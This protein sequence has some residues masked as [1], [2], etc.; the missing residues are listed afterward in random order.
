MPTSVSN[1]NPARVALLDDRPRCGPDVV[2]LLGQRAALDTLVLAARSIPGPACIAL[3]GPWGAGKSTLARAAY[4]E[5]KNHPGA[6]VVW[7][8]PWPYERGED[9]VTPLLISMKQQL[10][11][12]DT[13][14]N[15]KRL[16]SN[17]AKVALSFGTRALMGYWFGGAAGGMPENKG[18]VGAQAEDLEAVWE[19]LEIFHDAVAKSRVLF[20]QVVAE[21]LKGEI[22]EPRLYIFL[23]DLDR[24]L[25]DSVIALIEAVKL[26]LCGTADAFAVPDD[27]TPRPEVVFVFALDRTVVGEAI[28]TRYPRA[29]RYTGETYLEKIFDLSL[30]V[31]AASPAGGQDVRAM[32]DEIMS[33]RGTGAEAE[34]LRLD[35]GLA[36]KGEKSGG[37]GA[38]AQILMSPVFAN[39]RVMKRTWNRLTLL[40]RSPDA[41]ANV[42]TLGPAEIK[43]LIAWVAG[44]ERFSAFRRF[45]ADASALELMELD[46]QLKLSESSDGSPSATRPLTPSAFPSVGPLA[47][48]PGIVEYTRLLGLHRGGLQLGRWLGEQQVADGSPRT[49]G[50]YDRMLRRAGL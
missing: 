48:L 27:E 45:F 46:R 4:E 23:D 35:S 20:A 41:S 9:V 7:F 31:P 36:G 26:L 19:R 32:L 33:P 43:T 34:A 12:K 16:A 49:L 1:P 8:D 15:L 10:G 11:L 42:A 5:L 28:M 37:L 39:P 47:E 21:A 24:C 50:Y 6:K 30:Q 25:P 38:I 29:R 40:L 22:E 18:L 44:A 3:D 14:K 17:V 13:S 2:D